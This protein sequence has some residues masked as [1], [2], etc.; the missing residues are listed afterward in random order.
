MTFPF[1]VYLAALLIPMAITWVTLPL[2]VRW[3]VRI[4]LV[5]DPGHRKIH[6]RPIPLAGGPAVSTALLLSL[7]GAVLVLNYGWHVSGAGFALSHGFSR[8]TLQL[9][10][11]SIGALVIGVLGALDDRHELKPLPKFVGQSAVALLVAAAGVRVTLF[12]E[13]PTFSFTVTVLWMLTLINALN[14]MDN[15]NGLCAGIGAI[16]AFCFGMMAAIAGQHLVAALALLVAGALA[17]FLP[18]NFP[19]GKAFLGDAGSHLV[20]YLLAVL[21]ILPH[22]Y[23]EDSPRPFAVLTPLLVLA[24][25][26]A[27]LVNVVVIRTL[28]RKPFYIGD[29]NHFSHRLIRVGFSKTTA[30]L[31]LWLAGA[32]CGTLAV[33]LNR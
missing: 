7:L 30:V 12:V 29:T 5:D 18:H 17:G 6:N 27:D 14:F 24:V 21:A 4:G 13:S 25:P 19:E 3:C 2:W 8:R 26:L 28:D 10:V 1:N 16:A 9:L 23:S 11:I 33:W 22:F 20:G 15:M 32:L 31:L